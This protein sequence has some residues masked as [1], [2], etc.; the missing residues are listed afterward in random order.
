MWSTLSS[1]PSV[2]T[3]PRGWRR[4]SGVGKKQLRISNSQATLRS[5][6][7]GDARDY[8]A[9]SN[10]TRL[11]GSGCRSPSANRPER[12]ECFTRWNCSRY[13]FENS[14]RF[15]SP[16][17]SFFSFIC[18]LKENKKGFP[19]FSRANFALPDFLDFLN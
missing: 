11:I 6:I 2:R 5:P 3:S 7:N 8:V 1:V 15:F 14:C 18:F 9:T 19:C 13:H 4:W 12:P 10:L 17:S 16:V